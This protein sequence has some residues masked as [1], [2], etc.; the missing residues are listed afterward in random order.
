[1]L[2]VHDAYPVDGDPAEGNALM[3]VR[4]P[5]LHA[6]VDDE[7]VIAAFSEHAEEWRS[8][9]GRL[10]ALRG[11]G[12]TLR[13]HIHILAMRA[14]SA[15]E[16]PALVDAVAGP[17]VCVLGAIPNPD[18]GQKGTADLRRRQSRVTPGAATR[19]RG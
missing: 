4:H 3:I 11:A 1:V 8:F 6:D 10:E 5:Y 9:V 2:S 7:E 19:R 14:C 18:A 17:G 16:L 13:T 12:W 15:A